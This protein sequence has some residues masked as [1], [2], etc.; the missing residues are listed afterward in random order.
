MSGSGAPGGVPVSVVRTPDERFEALEGYGFDPHYAEVRAPGL[1]ALR[2]HYV[3]EG[4]RQGPVVLLLHGQPTWSYMYRRTIGVLAGRGFRVVAPDNIGFGRS[5]KPVDRTVYT[6]ERHVG[7]TTSLVDALDLRSV[8]LVVHDWGGPIGL[9][10][11]AADPARFSGV[12]ATNTVLHTADPA[13]DGVLT[14][15]N[16]GL[17][18]SRVVLEESLVDYVS[19]CQR[20]PE[21]WPSTLVYAASGRLRPEVLAGYDAPFPDAAFG[22]GLRQMSS[23]IPL[24]RND[25][26]AAI[27]RATMAVLASWERPFLTAFSDADPATRGWERVLQ[28]HVPGAAGLHHPVIAGAGHFVPEE[29]GGQLGRIVARFVEETTALERDGDPAIP[30][31]DRA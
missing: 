6:F 29:E 3:D 28:D 1:A 5:D 12:V 11:L 17:G 10:A 8:T 14:W 20:V 15:A 4:P 22:A 21:L 27:G 19:F 30:P 25:P 13:L 2:M 26:G 24:T 23:L 7:W 9:S 18:T 16:H 31:G